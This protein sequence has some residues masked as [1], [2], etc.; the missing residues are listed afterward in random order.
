MGKNTP[1]RVAERPRSGYI[2]EIISVSVK[3]KEP[4]IRLFKISFTRR[5]FRPNLLLTDYVT[6]LGSS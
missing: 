6:I 2:R 1:N 5:A 4:E 3:K